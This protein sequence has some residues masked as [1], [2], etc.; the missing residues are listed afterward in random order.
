MKKVIKI[1]LDDDCL[2]DLS[3]DELN[4]LNSIIK[5]SLSLYKRN[6]KKKQPIQGNLFGSKETIKDIK[7]TFEESNICN[8]NIFEKE[9]LELEQLGIDISFYYNKV[10]DWSINKPSIK[11]TSKGWIATT[12]N[13][14]RTAVENKK[15][16]MI[17]NIP[18]DAVSD[19]TMLEYLNM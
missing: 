10:K 14:I 4:K 11:R 13:F 8:W 3:I 19:A 18:K 9:M 7:T 12:R 16:I 2:T 15:V 6:L 1:N 5:T 17:N